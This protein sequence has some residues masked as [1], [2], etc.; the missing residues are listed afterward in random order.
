M[1]GEEARVE[2]MTKNT[3][4]S[5]S[6]AVTCLYGY[7]SMD[8]KHRTLLIP[9]KAT[10]QRNKVKDTK[11]KRVVTSTEEKNTNSLF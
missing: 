4:H 7:V 3:S 1:R 10:K 5:R 8:T 2:E 11:N 9:W 6:T